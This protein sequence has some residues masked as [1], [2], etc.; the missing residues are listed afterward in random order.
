MNASK[1]GFKI[2]ISIVPLCRKLHD[3]N[4]TFSRTLQ[5]LTSISGLS[6]DIINHISLMSVE[7]ISF[8][9]YLNF[10]LMFRINFN[11]YPSKIS[12]FGN[13]YFV[14]YFNWQETKGIL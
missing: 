11:I 6:I 12:P 13:F 4:Q 2:H 7:L 1:L 10:Y 9:H 8:V 3:Q 14:R 5:L